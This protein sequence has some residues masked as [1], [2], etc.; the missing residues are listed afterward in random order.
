[1]MY[2]T[3]LVSLLLPFFFCRKYLAQNE[4]G[5]KS[6]AQSID[7]KYKIGFLIS[8]RESMA[9][10]PMSHF[11]SYELSYNFH[12]RG[13]HGWEQANKNPS[14]GFVTTFIQNDNRQVLGNAF[15]I[16]GRIML[17]K[18]RWGKNHNWQLCNDMAFGLGYLEQKFNLIDNPKNVAI[19]SHLNLLIILGMEISYVHPRYFYSFGL[20]FTH[21]SNGGTI[22]PNLGLNIPSLKFG[23]GWMSKQQLYSEKLIDYDRSD[24][25]LLV[26]GVFSAK[27]NYEFQS[28][29]FPVIGLSA[30][31]SKSRGRRYRYNYGIDLI[32]S[33][34]NRQFLASPPNQSILKTAQIGVY[35]AYEL[36][37][38]RFILSVGMGAYVYNPLNPHGWFYHRIGGRIQLTER[39]YFLGYVRSHWAKADF[40]E[41]GISYKISVR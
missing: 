29:V 31:L 10:L 24:L 30:H 15:G 20:D 28:R 37:I 39:L 35:N 12:S 19:G 5:W 4:I 40:F 17:P 13:H 33:E 3:I 25:D 23:F 11:Q 2:R 9:H 41:T 7:F 32:Y 34:A 14:F 26:S 38:N 1:M 27:N 6:Y 8:H 36:E 22:K 16:S 18:K 21:F